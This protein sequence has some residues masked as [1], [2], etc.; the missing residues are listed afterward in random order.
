M[1]GCLCVGKGMEVGGVLSSSHAVCPD[2]P[3]TQQMA[4][5]GHKCLLRSCSGLGIVNTPS[6]RDQLPL[7]FCFFETRACCVAWAAL[8]LIV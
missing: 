4:T 6:G 2:W 5:S 3:F 7:L 1:L 8:E